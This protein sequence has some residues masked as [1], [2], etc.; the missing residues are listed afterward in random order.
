MK[1]AT[2][3]TTAGLSVRF[4]Q[5][6]GSFWAWAA[7]KLKN[8]GNR[9]GFVSKGGGVLC[10]YR[11]FQLREGECYAL[12]G[13]EGFVSAALFDLVEG[14][15]RKHAGTISMS[16]G[17]ISSR[18]Q[19]DQLRSNTT[20]QA[21]FRSRADLEKLLSFADL[22][23]QA[24]LRLED[25]AWSEKVRFSVALALLSSERLVVIDERLFACDTTFIAKVLEQIRFAKAQGRA[26][27]LAA[28]HWDAV[29]PVADKAIGFKI[30]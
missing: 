4:P 28:P 16:G 27:L 12:C 18:Q 25:L 3:L 5:S 14:K 20:L 11:G 10:E 24:S 19:F 22:F 7:G 13:R 26:F 1:S 30:S 23:A 2:L 9:D 6:G 15:Y 21:L 17:F 8:L 29:K